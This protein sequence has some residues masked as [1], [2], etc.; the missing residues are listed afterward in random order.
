MYDEIRDVICPCCDQQFDP[1]DHEVPYPTPEEIAKDLKRRR[2]TQ[3][4]NL[5]ILRTSAPEIYRKTRAKWWS[6]R[7]FRRMTK[8]TRQWAEKELLKMASP[9]TLLQK[10]VGASNV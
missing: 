1:Y 7:N 5:W 8:K 2:G 3:A 10:Y 9:M 6:D 4:N